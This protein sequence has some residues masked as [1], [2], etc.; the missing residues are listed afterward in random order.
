MLKFQK[1]D[2]NSINSTLERGIAIDADSIHSSIVDIILRFSKKYDILLT[3]VS[4]RVL[5]NIQSAK[6]KYGVR[7]KFVV[8]KTGENSADDYIVEHSCEFFLVITHDIPLSERL[9]NNNVNVIS[10]RG[11][12]FDENNIKTALSSRLI[13]NTLRENNLYEKKGQ[14]HPL[15]QKDIKNFSD[16][17]N[18]FLSKYYK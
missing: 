13:M 11:V 9:L 15:L 5:K 4:D 18:S 3:F 17:L 7:A 10:E 14:K 16:T 6:D 2:D 12:L 8:V 1:N